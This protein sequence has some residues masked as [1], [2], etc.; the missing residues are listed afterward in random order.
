MI[1]ERRQG[2]RKET[3]SGH[4]AR[5]A[6]SARAALEGVWTLGGGEPQALERIE[7]VGEE[8]ALPSVFPIGVAASACIGA[9]GLAAS[10]LCRLRAGAA[11]PVRVAMRNAA[12]AYRSEHYLRVDGGKVAGPDRLSLPAAPLGSHPCEWA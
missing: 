11:Q 12:V 5:R 3:R 6:M 7:L 2:Y 8:P 1:D 9:A 4:L 10:E